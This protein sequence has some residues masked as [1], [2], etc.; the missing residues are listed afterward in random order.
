MTFR[1]DLTKTQRTK[2]WTSKADTPYA[3]ALQAAY[4]AEDSVGYQRLLSQFRAE[5]AEKEGAD[6]KARHDFRLTDGKIYEI[7]DEGEAIDARINLMVKGSSITWSF[8]TPKDETHQ[9][10]RDEI[11]KTAAI[12]HQCVEH[13]CETYYRGSNAYHI[14]KMH[15]HEFEANFNHNH[16]RLVNDMPVT[17]S[18]LEEH[19][20]AFYSQELGKKYLSGP[21]EVDEILNVYK[22][23]WS[24]FDLDP[25]YS[26]YYPLQNESQK[27]SFLADLLDEN[28][29]S[30]FRDF[31]AKSSVEDTQVSIAL[32]AIE[33]MWEMISPVEEDHIEGLKAA[34]Q[35]FHLSANKDISAAYEIA[36]SNGL[37][38]G[39][40]S[41]FIQAM[42]EF[43]N[44]VNFSHDFLTVKGYYPPE[45]VPESDPYNAYVPLESTESSLAETVSSRARS[46]SDQYRSAVDQVMSFDDDIEHYL[47]AEALTNSC[48]SI[49]NDML[50]ELT[51]ELFRKGLRVYNALKY[52]N[53]GVVGYHDARFP[54]ELYAHLSPM[55]PDISDIFS[56]EEG[57]VPPLATVITWIQTAPPT[58]EEWLT[59]VEVHG[60]RGLG[61]ELAHTRELSG[62]RV[63]FFGLGADD[64]SADVASVTSLKPKSSSSS[65]ILNYDLR[66]YIASQMHLLG[67]TEYQQKT[68]AARDLLDALE[69]NWSHTETLD[70]AK[71]FP[72]SVYQEDKKDSHVEGNLYDLFMRTLFEIRYR[73]PA[74]AK[75]TLG[76]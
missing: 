69:K 45:D 34:L 28:K 70:L 4:D 13:G 21:Q 55:H 41:R 49:D 10:F 22:V 6:A 37:G 51:P 42:D 46:L 24:E 19:L 65:D 72:S 26:K 8:Q 57:R 39:I 64:R 2:K 5:I 17:P 7:T 32:D 33:Q 62:E 1:I 14:K 18:D 36:M 9:S 68:Q 50:G 16:Y 11:F 48:R 74:G 23:F 20:R 71:K 76:G 58:L 73:E 56:A 35:A 27:D 66:R 53:S 67:D 30:A 15:T 60:S 54:P 61:S 25:R 40:Y 47:Y 29:P 3:E 12:A 43:I 44:K 63:R 52:M 59:R 75:P 31:L 38:L